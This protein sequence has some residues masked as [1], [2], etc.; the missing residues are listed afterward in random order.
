MLRLTWRLKAWFKW[1]CVKDSTTQQSSLSPTD[2]PQ[3]L[4]PIASLSSMRENCK[5]TLT[6]TSFWSNKKA[7][8]PSPTSEVN[9]L[10]CL[11]RQEL[12]TPI[13]C[14]NTLRNHT[15]LAT[16][17]TSLSKTPYLWRITERARCT[18]CRSVTTRS[19]PHS[20]SI[21]R[22]SQAMWFD[23]TILLTSTQSIAYRESP[24]LMV[25]RASWNT[26]DTAST[27]LLNAHFSLKL[28]SCW[29]T[30][31]SPPDSNFWV[32]NH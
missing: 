29:S 16:S 27:S 3:L 9:S 8:R 30:D 10:V 21:S 13:L 26:A 24:T 23:R 7:I 2:S 32:S 25:K 28:P 6:H 1:L 17:T 5:N 31:S 15:S 18:S 4:M 11:F 22:M 12:R 20:C 14:L 19:L